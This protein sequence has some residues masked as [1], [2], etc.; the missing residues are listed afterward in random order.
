LTPFGSPY[1]DR[2]ANASLR[3]LD[4]GAE[5]KGVRTRFGAENRPMISPLGSDEEKA[6]DI[7]LRKWA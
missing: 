3:S 2:A 5:A 4:G 1:R 6:R 7:V